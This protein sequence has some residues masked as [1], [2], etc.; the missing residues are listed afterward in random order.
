[1]ERIKCETGRAPTILEK[2]MEIIKKL[3]KKPTLISE[4]EATYIIY[5]L[6][7]LAILECRQEREE[8]IITNIETCNECGKSVKWGSE[9]YINRIPDL[10]DK[11]TRL[12]MGKP[13]PDGEFICEECLI[14][15]QKTDNPEHFPMGKC[16]F[17]GKERKLAYRHFQTT[18]GFYCRECIKVELKLEKQGGEK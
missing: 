14:K 9:R 5:R 15:D 4:E 17:C 3:D 12:E 6:Y 10:N 7:H 18:S 2:D 13:F 16:N 1:M 11:E 8:I